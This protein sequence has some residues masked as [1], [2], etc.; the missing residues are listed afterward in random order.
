M[1]YK[2]NDMIEDIKKKGELMKINHY[3]KIKA[4]LEM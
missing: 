3:I 2:G 4:L 1:Q